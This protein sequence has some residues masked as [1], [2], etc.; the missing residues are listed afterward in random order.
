AM[1]LDVQ[2]HLRLEYDE[3]I[4]ESFIELRLQ[5]KTTETQA[6][7]SF[8]LAAGP[9]TK[10]SRYR[11]WNDNVVHH[12]AVTQYHDRLEVQSRW[13]VETRM[14]PFALSAI[15]DAVP[16][17]ALSHELRDWLFVDG[18][19]RRSERLDAFAAGLAVP[20][21]APLGDQVRR[22][23]RAIAGAFAYRKNVTRYDS[24]TDEFLH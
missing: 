20:E 24:T 3:F 2:H 22:I 21:R 1:F 17:P 11:D 9:P 10:I 16:L 4:R 8:V 23:S 13:L 6:V 15:E 19:L 12:F 18:P 14:P 5:P 7:A